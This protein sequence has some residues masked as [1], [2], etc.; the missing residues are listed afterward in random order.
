ML[1]QSAAPAVS[2]TS[3][4]AHWAGIVTSKVAR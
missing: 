4:L 2:G 3:F 1:P